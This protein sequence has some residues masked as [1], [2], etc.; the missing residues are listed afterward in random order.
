MSW[1]CDV[2]SGR[3]KVAQPTSKRPACA[4]RTRHA[5]QGKWYV[6][7]QALKMRKVKSRHKMDSDTN[8]PMYLM[9]HHQ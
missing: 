8:H 4:Q 2:S 7:N 3:E 5:Y 9:T 6:L 1:M